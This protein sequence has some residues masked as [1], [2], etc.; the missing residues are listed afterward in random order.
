MLIAF[1]TWLLSQRYNAIISGTSNATD[2]VLF[3]IWI[4]FIA[5]FI[6]QEVDFFG[7]RL[8]KEIHDLKSEFKE[9]II[10]LRSDVQNTINMR[11]E[12]SQQIQLSI[13]PTESELKEFINNYKPILEQI[14]GRGLEKA[15]SKI[16]IP[17]DNK[18]L[19]EVRYVI[20]KELRRIWGQWQAIT[21]EIGFWTGRAAEVLERPQS[22]FQI[23]RSLSELGTI[24]PQLS[25]LL[26]EV[27][28]ACSPAVHGEEVSQTA[29]GFVRDVAPGLIT[30]LRAINVAIQPKDKTK[31]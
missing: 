26:R 10:N 13:P 17:D 11:T 6:F 24:T 31:E 18:F 3:L 12:I 7:V 4:A 25:S 19:F 16:E 23:I 5:A 21:R 14:K 29:I 28:R 30:S 22:S 8:K 2:I 20:E 27:Y 15:T 9:Q 1:F